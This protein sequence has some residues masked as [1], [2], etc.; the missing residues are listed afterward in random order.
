MS[1]M[2]EIPLRP[3]D[4]REPRLPPYFSSISWTLRFAE[5]STGAKR[6][7]DGLSRFP[8]PWKRG[9]LGGLPDRRAFAQLWGHDLP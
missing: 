5:L 1:T 3:T 8:F 2:I 9:C 6:P 4:Q 7:H